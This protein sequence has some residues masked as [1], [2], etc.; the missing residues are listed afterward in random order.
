[1][2]VALLVVI[3]ALATEIVSEKETKLKE[4]MKMMG[5]RESVYWITWFVTATAVYFLPMLSIAGVMC[6]TPYQNS[7]YG[8]VLLFYFCF[9]WSLICL[10]F[11]ITT[12]INKARI[13][14]LI[15]CIVIVVF[16]ILGPFAE[17]TDSVSIGK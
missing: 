6:G 7:A 2:T 1:M 3:Y 14:G 13:S 12:F 16:A 9:A 4:G 5:L 17:K 11:L 15:T 8:L 10:C